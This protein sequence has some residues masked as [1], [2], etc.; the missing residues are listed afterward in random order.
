ME[1]R[2]AEKVIQ[3]MP[4]RWCGRISGV[5]FGVLSL[6]FPAT[7]KAAE[8]LCSGDIVFR[9]GSG[10]WSEFIRRNTPRDQRFSHVGI[11]WI[12]NGV[13]SVIHADG[14]DFSGHGKV[15]VVPWTDFKR[16]AKRIAFFRLKLSYDER[17]KFVQCAL[18]LSGRDFDWKFDR[19]DHSELYCTELLYV[20]LQESK[21]GWLS[22]PD[23]PVIPLSLFSAPEIAREMEIEI[24]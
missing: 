15:G 18:K 8:R 11:I 20:A 9:H 24:P 14:D 3:L 19:N 22:L 21:P 4:V 12:N 23:G 1:G 10:F 2:S 5:L 13:I 17:Q 7:G 16:T 6:F